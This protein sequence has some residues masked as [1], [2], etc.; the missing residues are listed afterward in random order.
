MALVE[1]YRRRHAGWNV[2]PFQ[3]GTN[4]TGAARGNLGQEPAARGRCGAEGTWARQAPQAAHPRG[5]AGHD[6]APGRKHPRLGTGSEVGLGRNHGR[7]HQRALLDALVTEVRCGLQLHGR[8]RRDQ[9]TRVVRL[10]LHR[11][12]QPLLVYPGSWR[13]G[14]QEEPHAIWQGHGPLGDRDDPGLLS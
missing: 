5:R 6:A 2:K 12:G 1:R 14:S 11:S 8:A 3:L 7:R 10:A 4:A 13:Q 9:A